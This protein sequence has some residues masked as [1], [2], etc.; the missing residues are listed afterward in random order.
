[1]NNLLEEFDKILTENDPNYH[2][3]LCQQERDFIKQ[4]M[5]KAYNLANE[6]SGINWKEFPKEK[7]TLLSW[8][9][10]ERY[11]VIVEGLK[12]PIECSWLFDGWHKRHDG[13]SD[14]THLV[15]YFTELPK[16]PN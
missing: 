9:Q 3:P 2:M 8:G 1:M 6:K 13:C 5:L 7:P 4:M 10:Y 11:L 15:K 12:N 14:I 16:K